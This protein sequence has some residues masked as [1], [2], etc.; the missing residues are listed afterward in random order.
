MIQSYG[1]EKY[2]T[3]NFENFQHCFSLHSINKKI[4]I[5][6]TKLNKYLIYI[7]LNLHCEA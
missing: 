5:R 1:T 3:V 6:N 2:H 4:S 7:I